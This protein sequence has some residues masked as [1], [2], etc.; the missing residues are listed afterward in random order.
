MLALFMRETKNRMNSARIRRNLMRNRFF[1][2]TVVLLAIAVFSVSPLLAQCAKTCKVKECPNVTQCKAS[3]EKLAVCACGMEFTVNE[4]S[5]SIEVGKKTYYACSEACAEK[6]RANK[7]KMI[8]ALEEKASV[9]KGKKMTGCNVTSVD[10][11]GRK[12]AVCACGGEFRISKSAVTREHNGETIFFCCENC[13][14]T[15]D[16]DPEGTCKMIHEKMGGKKGE[17]L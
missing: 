10:A 4:N 12:T 14:A 6:I 3:G 16:K 9:V 17:S 11:K 1:M 8:P 7:D 13:A 15:F 2:G 5:P